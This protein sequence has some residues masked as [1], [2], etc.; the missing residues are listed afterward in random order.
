MR[1][2]DYLYLECWVTA[3]NC[4]LYLVHEDYYSAST[5]GHIFEVSR[6]E[7][8]FSIM[9]KV[10]LL[11]GG[12]SGIFHRVKAEG[13]LIS[14]NRKILKVTKLSVKERD[15]DFKRVIIDDE[16]LKRYEPRY[17][18]FLQKFSDVHSDDWLDYV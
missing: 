11:G 2:R 3:A 14:V 6:P 13:I 17:L 10:L 18:E 9:E 7:I 16:Y 5:S 15:G 1:I 4:K 8:M 12:H